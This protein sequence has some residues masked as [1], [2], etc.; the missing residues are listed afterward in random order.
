MRWLRYAADGREAYGII[1]GDEVVEVKG[2]PFAGYE[3]TA[4]R[5]KLDRVK[6]LVPVIPKNPIRPCPR[7]RFCFVAARGAQPIRIKNRSD[8]VR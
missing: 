7:G 1:E 5:R 6:F 4:T 2:D 3:R 8:H